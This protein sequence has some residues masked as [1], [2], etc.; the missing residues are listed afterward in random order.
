MHL[1]R[2]EPRNYCQSHRRRPQQCEPPYVSGCKELNADI[3]VIGEDWGNKTHSIAVE[4]YLK[5]KGK[6]IIQILFSPRTS[7]SRIKHNTI[8]QSDRSNYIEQAVA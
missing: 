8:V 3:F 2:G 6:E 4:S 5:G 1:A 7:S